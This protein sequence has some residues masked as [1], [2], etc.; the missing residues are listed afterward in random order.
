MG[1]QPAELDRALALLPAS[2]W[3]MSSIYETTRTGVL[4]RRVVQCA[5]EPVCLC[6]ALRKGSRIDPVVRDSR[7][8]AV[9]LM[10]TDGAD[11]LLVKKFDTPEATD[12]D[13]FDAYRVIR[14]RTGSPVMSKA[15]V[16]FDCEV[17]SHVDLEADSE[18]YIGRVVE[19]II[20][21]GLPPPLG[22]CQAAM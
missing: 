17:L 4:V 22:D 2:P 12:D 11:R 19:A 5:D 20:F 13:P 14:L 8:F 21:P 1:L 18:L 16:A 15:L 6:I 3:V 9:S 10:P 7:V